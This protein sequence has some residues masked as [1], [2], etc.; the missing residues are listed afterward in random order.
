MSS[1]ILDI[2]AKGLIR[3][4]KARYKPASHLE[5]AYYLP[6]R[7]YDLVRSYLIGASGF[8]EEKYGKLVLRR[9]Y[10]NIFVYRR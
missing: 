10:Y 9:R 6:K 5:F 1:P 3:I 7:T 2:K 4:V 8:K